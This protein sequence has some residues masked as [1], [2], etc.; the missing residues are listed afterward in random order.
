MR[1]PSSSSGDAHRSAGSWR[2]PS[3]SRCPRPAARC[4]PRPGRSASETTSNASPRSLTSSA[5]ASSTARS[6]SSSVSPRLRHDHDAL[7][8]EQ[9]GHRARVGH[10]AAVAG[11]RDAHLGGG[12]VAVVGQALDE[13][14]D[15]V[16]AVA[17]VHD[18]LV[19]GAAGLQAGAALD[20]AL[21]VVVRDRGLLRLLDGVVERRV[22]GRVAAAGPRRDLDVLDQLGEQ[23]AALGVDRRPSCAWWSPTWSGRS[24]ACSF[25]VTDLR[26]PAI[27]AAPPLARARAPSRRTARAPGG[28]RSAPGGTTVASSG[29]WRTAT[30]LR[31]SGLGG[32]APRRPAPT[33]S[34][35][36]AR[37]NTPCTGP[38]SHPGEV[39]VGLERVDLPAEGVAAHDHVDA[40]DGLLARPRPSRTCRP[41]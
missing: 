1:A 31:P 23:L 22:A 11:H 39:E 29:P 7:A 4:A 18:R 8:V 13:H 15:A 34:T 26:S 24:S 5:P 21:D 30:T 2:R 12:A 28:H 6:T 17:L 9:V 37:M 40:A 10:R 19:V 33:A 27:R 16:G 3:R 25:A 38:P 41:A 14:R 32:P 20:R 35:Q 36:G